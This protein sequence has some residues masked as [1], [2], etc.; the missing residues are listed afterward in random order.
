[1]GLSTQD[2]YGY[3]LAVSGLPVEVGPPVLNGLAAAVKERG[4]VPAEGL[5]VQGE[6]S[7]L[8]LH[9]ADPDWPFVMIGHLTGFRSPVWQ[10]VWPDVGHRFPGEPG[11]ALTSRDQA[12]FA[13]PY[14]RDPTI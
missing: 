7:P 5:T 3:E 12:D 4:I 1:V 11:C 9:A 10:A 8:R 6:G 2:E 14:P 13:L